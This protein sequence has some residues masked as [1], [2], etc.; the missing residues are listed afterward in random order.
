[1]GG[2][3]AALQHKSRDC[4]TEKLTTVNYARFMDDKPPDAVTVSGHDSTP[5]CNIRL[6]LVISL[7]LA[8]MLVDELLRARP[9]QFG[10]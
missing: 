10:Q 4:D 9:Y 1:M 3:V 2:V 6:R 8:V 7:H 5:G